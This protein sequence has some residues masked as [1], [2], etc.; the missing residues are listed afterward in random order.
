MTIN[1]PPLRLRWVSPFRS[2]L[3]GRNP[4]PPNTHRVSR[5][6]P[7]CRQAARSAPDAPRKS[8]YSKAE[9]FPGATPQL[10]GSARSFGPSCLDVWGFRKA[11]PSDTLPARTCVRLVRLVLTVL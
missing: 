8:A 5:L 4:P 2:G 7:V 10:D 1:G 6:P 11:R 3:D 9:G